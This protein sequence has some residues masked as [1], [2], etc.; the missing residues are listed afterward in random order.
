MPLGQRIAHMPP[1][2]RLGLTY[3]LR[4]ALAESPE[5]LLEPETRAHNVEPSPLRC[6]LVEDA[7]ELTQAVL[8]PAEALSGRLEL[9]RADLVERIQRFGDVVR[10]RS[11]P[12]SSSRFAGASSALASSARTSR[13][14]RASLPLAYA[15]VHALGKS[16]SKRAEHSL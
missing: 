15:G 13:S 9:P 16:E 8:P 10:H 2:G 6:D 5:G 3:S 7:R 1:E 11:T 12:A 4:L 14:S